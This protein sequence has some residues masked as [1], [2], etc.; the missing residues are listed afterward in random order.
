MSDEAVGVDP[1]DSPAP[2][3][4]AMALVA[5]Q[6]AFAGLAGSEEVDILPAEGDDGTDIVVAGDAWSLYLSGWPGPATAFIAVEEE[7]D[8]AADAATVDAA[9][10]SAVDNDVVAAL[11]VADFDLGGGLTAALDASGDALSGAVAAA[12]RSAAP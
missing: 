4:H 11:M 3:D 2:I 5:V 7:P 6:T 9:W 12:V 1:T 8:E 10:R